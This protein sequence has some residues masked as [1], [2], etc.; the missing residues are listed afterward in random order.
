VQ[1]LA[2]CAGER[3]QH[4]DRQLLAHIF[5]ALDIK[6]YIQAHDAP[7]RIELNLTG[8]IPGRHHHRR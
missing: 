2:D 6:V 8:D 7:D 5:E 4:P 1:R 3:L